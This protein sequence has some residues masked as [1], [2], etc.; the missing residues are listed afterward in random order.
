MDI[1][2]LSALTISFQLFG[3][4]FSTQTEQESKWPD[5]GLWTLLKS[6]T[7]EGGLL[8]C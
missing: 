4:A 6:L 1:E 7:D 8:K 2:R 5:S 3:S